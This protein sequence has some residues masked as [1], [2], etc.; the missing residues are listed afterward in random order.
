MSNVEASYV[1]PI[2]LLLLLCI[3]LL[4]IDECSKSECT[5][6]QLADTSQSSSCYKRDGFARRMLYRA[7]LPSC[8]EKPMAH[9]TEKWYVLDHHGT[10][11][12]GS[13]VVL[14]CFPGYQLPAPPSSGS[15]EVRANV[16]YFSISGGK[17]NIQF[18]HISI[19][20]NWNN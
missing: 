3:G 15:S 13:T 6:S 9:M 18:I 14:R 2:L 5:A 12:Y 8:P 19:I 10:W 20:Q 11:R 17:L 16:E 4:A 7:W 1:L